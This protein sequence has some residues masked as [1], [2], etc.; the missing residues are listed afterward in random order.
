M[1]YESILKPLLFRLDPERV[2]EEVSGLLSLLAPVPGAAHLL[3]L[4]TGRGGK[5]LGRRVFGL[6]FPNP[7]G[8]AAGYDKDGALAPLLSALGFGFIEIGSVTLEPQPG[9]PRPRLFRLPESRALLNRMGFNSEGA[10]LVARRLSSQTKPSIPLGINIGLN[11]NTPPEKAPAAYAR[12]FRILSDH[13]DYFAIN[14]SSPNTPGL[15]DL[16]KV[17]E[18]SSILEAVQDANPS[19][20]PVL[21][22]LSPDLAEEDLAATVETASRLAQGLILANTTIERNG[23]DETWKNEK[24]GLSGQPLRMRATELIKRARSLTNIPIIGVGGI[25]TAEDVEERLSAGA[26]LVQIYTGLVYGGPC[27]VKHVTKRLS[28]SLNT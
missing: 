14:I 1:L 4:L 28:C 5:G 17:K 12:T 11:K 10:R 7:V 26:D 27:L 21:V 13:G 24:G 15:R 23:L 19:R 9:N 18:L 2:H 3:S 20:K 22:K 16:Q 8:L 25:E 6:D